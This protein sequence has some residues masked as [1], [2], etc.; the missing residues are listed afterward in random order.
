M[1]IGDCVRMTDIFKK[2]LAS[3][4]PSTEKGVGGGY[5]HLKE[6]GDCV[7][8]IQGPMFQDPQAPELDVRWHPSNLRYGYDPS[9]LELAIPAI[10]FSDFVPEPERAFAVLRDD[11]DWDRRGDTP[12][13]EYYCND[14]PDP[15]MYGKGK[16]RR[17]YDPRP[18]HPQIIAIRTELEKFTRSTFEVCFLNRY[19]NQSDQLGWHADDSPEMDDGRP[20]AV[21]SLGVARE[22]WFREKPDALI[23]VGE[24]QR[25][26]EERRWRE[27][28]TW[29]RRTEAPPTSKLLLGNGSLCLMAPGMQDTHQHRIPK[30]SFKCGERISLTF[31]GYV[32]EKRP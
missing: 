1:N 24:D 18:Y 11:L 5:E 16:G 17:L 2:K 6:F 12:R 28:L 13:H 14:F 32:Q 27:R 15:Y 26:G 10:Y 30:A 19:L 20:I 9:Q 7:G 22:I 25:S 4:A 21:V 3:E 31:R 8:V 23:A 29:K